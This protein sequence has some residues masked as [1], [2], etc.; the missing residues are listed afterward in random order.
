[1]EIAVSN[2][3][4]YGLVFTRLITSIALNPIFSRRNMPMRIRLGFVLVLT[5]LIAPLVNTQGI[6]ELSE[7]RFILYLFKEAL[8]GFVFGYL[9]QLFQF[10]LFFVGDLLDFHFGLSMAK[11]FDPSTTMQVS[12]VGNYL[13]VIFVVMFFM[14][15]SHLHLIR[16]IVMSFEY[17]PLFEGINV[18][19][20]SSYVMDAF[21]DVFMI[22]LKLALPFIFVQFVVEMAMG[23]L[24]T[25]IPQ[26]HVFVINIQLKILVGI[27][28][29]IVMLQPITHFIDEYI[30][31]MIKAIQFYLLLS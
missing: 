18:L 19:A 30:G 23:V 26:I 10:M 16:L 31:T 17:M 7:I 29:L 9:T 22:A 2:T 24:M 20:I 28:L 14:S 4:V 12:S 15:G 1:M 27:I 13:Q 11:I 5:L 8:I 3:I 6:T 25:L 21:L